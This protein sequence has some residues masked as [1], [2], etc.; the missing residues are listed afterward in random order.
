M[1]IL[2]ANVRGR[3]RQQADFVPTRKSNLRFA[4]TWLVLL[5]FTWQSFLTQT[6]IHHPPAVALIGDIGANALPSETGKG[7]KDRYPAN[8]DPANCPLC[9]EIMH[10]GQVI[11]PAALLLVLPSYAAFNF[12]VFVETTTSVRAP[13]HIWQGRAPPAL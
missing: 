1:A 9:Q 13:S 2:S 3:R 4:L 5:A 11:V 12:I 10:A 8:E 7:S 6:H